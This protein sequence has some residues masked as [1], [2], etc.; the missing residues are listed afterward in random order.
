MDS[1]K[2]NSK[3][4]TFIMLKGYYLVFKEYLV[5]SYRKVLLR[6]GNFAIKN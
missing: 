1:G 2:D 6:K 4:K 5:L 3:N